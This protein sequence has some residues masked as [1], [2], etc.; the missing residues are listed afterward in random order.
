VGSV[1]DD[2]DQIRIDWGSIH[3]LL[4]NGKRIVTARVWRY[5]G[6][7]GGDVC[8]GNR[9]SQVPFLPRGPLLTTRNRAQPLSSP[10]SR[11]GVG[12]P[13]AMDELHT[14]TL[15]DLIA[16]FQAGENSALD[17]L[18]RR[19]Q[20][21]LEQF[22]RRMLGSFPRRPS[23][24][25]GRGRSAERTDPANTGPPPGDPATGRGFFRPGRPSHP[26]RI[27]RPGPRSTAPARLGGEGS[28]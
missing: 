27:T 20:E 19:T 12:G 14:T 25:T 2:M 17:P 11:R 28:R 8:L 7:P 9:R 10:C 15:R 23:Q 24:R 13:P 22:A 4:S 6:V 21:R 3:C 18:I 16:R 26:P 1:P 5:K